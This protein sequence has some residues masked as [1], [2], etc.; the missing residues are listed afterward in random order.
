MPILGTTGLE[1]F[2]LCL[3]GNVFGWTADEPQSFAVLDAYVAAGGNFVDTANLYSH[4]APGNGGGVSEQVIGNWLTARGNRDEIVLATKV[5]GAFGDLEGGLKPKTIARA[6]DESLA[7]LQTDHI[8][9]YY[10]HFDDPDTPLEETLEAFDALV[11]AGK[12]RHLAASNHPVERLEAALDVSVREGFAAYEIYQPHYSLVERGFEA[13]MQ[14]LLASRGIGAVPYWV[15]AQGFLLGKYRGRTG[16]DA[17]ADSPRAAEAS[18]YADRGGAAVLDVLDDLAAAHGTTLGPIV[19]AWT[20]SRETVVAPIASARTPEQLA[21]LL[22]FT[23]IELGLDD[24]ARLD[25]AANA[26]V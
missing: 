11:K 10:A 26:A 4:W 20:R 18:A 3:G 24:I 21:Q 16:D 23:G 13:G 12:V 8:D 19:L 22:P 6:C 7:R 25:A 14:A 5:G 15:L 17:G 2:D 1:V 9:L